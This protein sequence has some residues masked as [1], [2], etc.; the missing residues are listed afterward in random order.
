MPGHDDWEPK[1]SDYYRQCGYPLEILGGCLREVL[2][3]KGTKTSEEIVRHCT[4]RLLIAYIRDI[5]GVW[6]NA[7]ILGDHDPS[8]SS[9]L[10]VMNWRNAFRSLEIEE[11]SEE[12]LA[13]LAGHWR[14]A[15][16]SQGIQ[17]GGDE[18]EKQVAELAGKWF[19]VLRESTGANDVGAYKKYA[20]RA[21]EWRKEFES[22]IV[23]ETPTS[24][25]AE[26]DL[27]EEVGKWKSELKLKNGEFSRAKKGWYNTFIK[28]KVNSG[29]IG[30]L[31]PA[32]V[33]G[34]WK[35]EAEWAGVPV[36]PLIKVNKLYQMYEAFNAIVVEDD[37]IGIGGGGLGEEEEQQRIIAKIA[38]EWNHRLQ[39]TERKPE[40]SAHD[41][42]MW[43][44]KFGGIGRGGI[45]Q[46]EAWIKAFTSPQDH[47]SRFESVDAH[48]E[49]EYAWGLRTVMSQHSSPRDD[50]G[51]VDIVSPIDPPPMDKLKEMAS[52]ASNWFRLLGANFLGI[53]MNWWNAFKSLGIEGM[54]ITEELEEVVDGWRTKFKSLGIQIPEDEG[55]KQLAELAARWFTV[56]EVKL[57]TVQIKEGKFDEGA[58]EAGEWRKTFKFILPER[59]AELD[60]AEEAGKWWKMELG[61]DPETIIPWYHAFNDILVEVPVV[62][63]AGGRRGE[64]QSKHP[65]EVAKEWQI[66]LN[67]TRNRSAPLL[68][69][70]I[71]MWYDAFA[72]FEQG[73]KEA[74]A[75]NAL[76]NQRFSKESVDNRIKYALGMREIMEPH[77]RQYP[78][79]MMDTVIETMVE[80]IADGWYYLLGQEESLV[81]FKQVFTGLS[82][83]ERDRLNCWENFTKT[84][85]LVR[86]ILVNVVTSLGG[87]ENSAQDSVPSEAALKS[88]RER[89][90]SPEILGVC[91]REVLINITETGEAK[92]WTEKCTER[93][94]TSQSSSFSQVLTTTSTT[95]TSAPAVTSPYYDQIFENTGW[96][97][98]GA[99]C[100][101]VSL[102]MG[103]KKKKRRVR[104]RM[105]WWRVLRRGDHQEE[106][107]EEVEEERRIFELPKMNEDSGEEEKC[108]EKKSAEISDDESES[109]ESGEEEEGGC[110]GEK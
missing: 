83:K 27:V 25:K 7:L 85:E 15:F 98:L 30:G 13:E 35:A 44:D 22:I 56:L 14:T 37:G 78:A 4:E 81:I 38:V 29:E 21:L 106:D 40:L 79:E 82:P 77:F 108:E 87:G 48:A 52:I 46:A 26:L 32:Q 96:F 97:L 91:L 6:K 86:K 71:R 11:I 59:T 36:F 12:Q 2:V 104:R 73:E 102:R 72:K 43:Y 89:K 28:L 100:L 95:V 109:D 20:E 1:H 49:A 39:Q 103:Q 93:L 60:L 53:F 8:D 110:T 80:T 17:T 55:E 24:S 68:P 94:R 75:W 19:T 66:A 3:N 63:E 47:H 88:Y 105:W 41:V 16:E 76:A 45:R 90:Y 70:D 92:G 65:A 5:E 61:G 9:P 107:A 69:S 54:L 31:H 62:V 23:P 84:Q 101:G 99:L 42:K 74:G 67:D 51:A 34:I 58:E 10:V 57:R 64:Q 50:P 33:A 18:G